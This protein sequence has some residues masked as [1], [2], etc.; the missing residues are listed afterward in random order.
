MTQH[1]RT[2]WTPLWP[3]IEPHIIAAQP[4]RRLPNPN[5]DGWIGPIHSPL[6]HDQHPSFSIKPDT[7]TDPGSYKDHASGDS[8]PIS[9]LSQ[10]LNIDPHVSVKPSSAVPARTLHEFCAQRR[11]D[12]EHLASVWRV[13]QTQWKGRPALRYPTTLSIDRIKYLD[14]RRPKYDWVQTGGHRHWYGLD[15][16]LALGAPLYIVNGEPA[17]WAAQQEGVAAICLCAGEGI[18][19]TPDMVAE[20]RYAGISDVRV[21][22][23]VDDAGRAGAPKVVVALRAGGLSAVALELP[24]HL[25]DG[26]DVDDLHRWEGTNLSAALEALPELSEPGAAPVG[27]LLAEVK[28]EQ[29]TWFWP[30]RIP[31]GKLTVWDG[32]PDLGKSAI[33]LDLAARQSVGAPLPDG[34]P[35]TPAGV[36]LLSAEDGVNLRP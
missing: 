24:S 6:R 27:V 13:H 8:G 25:G 31:Y 12:P 21:V 16:A 33:T 23:D 35:T 34:S 1:A 30:G 29:V 32:D 19:P 5:A 36:V 18:E 17:V 7:P 14:N 22:Y 3:M 10:Q 28:A 4:K 20:L 2:T 9:K 15:H 11:L 26:G